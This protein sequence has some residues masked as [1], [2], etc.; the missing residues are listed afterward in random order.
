MIALIDTN[1]IIDFL[2]TREPFFQSASQIME[3]CATGEIDGC[4]AFHTIPNL[5]YILRKV[6][7]EKR[8]VWIEKICECLTVVGASHE[9]VVQAVR[10]SNFKDFEDCLQDRCAKE[11]GADYIVTRNISDFVESNVPAIEPDRLLSDYFPNIK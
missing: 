3:K 11:A 6:P 2:A 8:R 5:W 10:T 7:E 4:V 1:I 9:S